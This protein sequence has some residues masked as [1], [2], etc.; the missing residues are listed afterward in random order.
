MSPK[1]LIKHNLTILWNTPLKESAWSRRTLNICVAQVPKCLYLICDHISVDLSYSGI[2]CFCLRCRGLWHICSCTNLLVDTLISCLGLFFFLSAS[3]KSLFSFC[4]FST[5]NF[6]SNLK[7]RRV[8]TAASSWISRCRLVPV[9][10]SKTNLSMTNMCKTQHGNVSLLY[11]DI[12]H[13]SPTPLLQNPSIR[14]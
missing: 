2:I 6:L 11:L 3:L 12:N 14:I 1:A 4:V 9:K 5:G 10:P 8:E 7:M 13:V